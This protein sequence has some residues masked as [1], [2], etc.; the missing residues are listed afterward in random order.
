MSK[1]TSQRRGEHRWTTRQARSSG[2]REE[3]KVLKV[4][5]ERAVD[6]FPSD[7][8]ERWSLNPVE[9][10]GEFQWALER[11]NLRLFM[12]SGSQFQGRGRNMSEDLLLKN[13]RFSD[14]T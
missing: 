4:G 12:R 10:A 8:V 2:G 7:G 5:H 13:E 11:R 9:G 6:A 3:G 14:R 1:S